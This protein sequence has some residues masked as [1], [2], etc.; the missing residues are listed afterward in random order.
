MYQDHVPE[1]RGNYR[2]LRA[3]HDYQARR[4][5]RTP[6][7]TL[8]VVIHPNEWPLSQAIARICLDVGLVHRSE[9][10]T[11]FNECALETLDAWR[12]KGWLRFAKSSVRGSTD[13]LVDM[14]P[15][16]YAAVTEYEAQTVAFI[17]GLGRGNLTKQKLLDLV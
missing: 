4:M 13:I 1:F 12:N 14:A 16:F 8:P 10:I 2:C 5:S 11:K 15:E 6:T 3:V 17:W 9:L 7:P